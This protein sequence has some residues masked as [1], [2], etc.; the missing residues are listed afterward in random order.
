MP[1]LCLYYTIQAGELDITM[2]REYDQHI[3]S[4][5]LLGL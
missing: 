3:I 4:T 2:I 5:I 1:F